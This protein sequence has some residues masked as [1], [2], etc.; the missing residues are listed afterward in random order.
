MFIAIDGLSE[1]VPD[2][3][4]KVVSVPAIAHSGKD[5]GQIQSKDLTEVEATSSIPAAVLD[6]WEV[7]SHQYK[8]SA[9]VEASFLARLFSAK[10]ETANYGLVQEAKR[11]CVQTTAMK[12]RVEHGTA[13][14]L[15]VA[16]FSAKLE[17]SLTLP[18]IAAKAQLGHI[19]ARIALSVDGY[20]GPLGDLLPA[21]D[22]LN[23]ENLVV[24]TTAFKNIQAR[25]FG[26]DGLVYI[27]PTVLGYDKLPGE[28]A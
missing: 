25:I 13:V 11:F 9:D 16:V 18:N 15:S 6:R 24:Y 10:G 21:P 14:R 17:G 3:V 5:K 2:D 26:A 7:H 12:R 22:N 23:V 28:Q 8:T 1:R 19:Q 4:R 27:V 20:A